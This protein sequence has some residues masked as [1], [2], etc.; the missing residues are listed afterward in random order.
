MGPPYMLAATVSNRS[1]SPLS[2]QHLTS[3]LRVLAVY[4]RGSAEC[5]CTNLATCVSSVICFLSEG[6]RALLCVPGRWR[7]RGRREERRN[8]E[9]KL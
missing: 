5:F 8:K 4:G 7:R 3:P 2:G 9:E 6:V 1:V